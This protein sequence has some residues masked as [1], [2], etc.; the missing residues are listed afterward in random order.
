MKPRTREEIVA[1]ELAEILSTTPETVTV[2]LASGDTLTVARFLA[3]FMPG[4][5]IIPGWLYEKIKHG[6]HTDSKA[7]KPSGGI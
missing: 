7:P 1:L 6:A 2:R 4:R 3:D 5:I